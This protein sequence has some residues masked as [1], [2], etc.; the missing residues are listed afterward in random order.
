MCASCA[1][2]RQGGGMGVQ[3]HVQMDT[4]GL[5]HARPTDPPAP[6]ATRVAHKQVVPTVGVG[7]EDAD[8][9]REKMQ[10]HFRGLGEGGGGAPRRG[11]GGVHVR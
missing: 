4:C 6:R 3:T 7:G 11:C 1:L 9:A 2:T 8:R 10:R 5:A